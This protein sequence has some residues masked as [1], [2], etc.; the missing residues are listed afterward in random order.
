VQFCE[1]RFKKRCRR[2]VRLNV[3]EQW[4]GLRLL[5][6]KPWDK[7]KDVFPI[8]DQEKLIQELHDNAL[9][10][11]FFIG[12][13]GVGKSRFLYTLY[14]EALWSKKATFC[15]KTSDLVSALKDNEFQRLPEERWHEIVTSDDI[16]R[17][18]TPIHIFLDEFDKIP[19][20]DFVYN[21][22]FKLIDTIYEFPSRAKLSVCT[23][24]SPAYFEEIWGKAL[25]RRLTEVCRTHRLWRAK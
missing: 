23:N 9:E 19:S 15:S 4:H 11:H 1:C 14:Q 17:R 12:P 2:L 24:L 16:R 3:P 25:F 5:D 10:G 18:E 6:L 13:S 20:T 8:A 7:I 22:I 21:M